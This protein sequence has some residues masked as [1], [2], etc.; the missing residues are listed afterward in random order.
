MSKALLVVAEASLRWNSPGSGSRCAAVKRVGPEKTATASVGVYRE[1]AIERA[2]AGV[3]LNGDGYGAGEAGLH[4]AIVV[5]H[6]D[7][8]TERIAGGDTAGGWLG[9]HDQLR[10]LRGGNVKGVRGRGG[11]SG[12][13]G[14]DRVAVGDLI[15]RQAGESGHP[16]A[17]VYRERAI[18][19]A[20]PGVA[21]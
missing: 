7:S 3:A 14:L 10:G 13:S 5:F 2:A 8:Q 18:E 19:C 1:G 6:R 11:E 16:G 15:D 12:G 20:V 17:G 4:V 21:L 9:R